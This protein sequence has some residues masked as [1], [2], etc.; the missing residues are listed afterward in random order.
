MLA[1]AAHLG[2]G[3]MEGMPRVAEAEDEEAATQILLARMA[4][5]DLGFSR[6]GE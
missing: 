1:E 5:R 2:R 4:W 6:R 3:T